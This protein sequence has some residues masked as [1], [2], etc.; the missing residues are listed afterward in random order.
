MAARPD[1]TAG[2]AAAAVRG[3]IEID[4]PPAPAGA[5]VD[6]RSGTAGD[7]AG[8]NSGRLLHEWA[9]PEVI[10]DAADGD[11]RLL[12]TVSVQF[13]VGGE[14]AGAQPHWHGPAWNWLLRGRRRWLLWPPERATYAQRHVALALDAAAR[15]GGAPPECEQRAGDVLLVPPLWGHATLNLAP[16]LGF[17]TEL[18][19]DRAFDLGAPEGR[20]AE[21]STEG[22]GT[23]TR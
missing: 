10:G 21:G 11:E 23:S 15:T 3:D 17:A 6:K 5:A 13:Y 14:G 22:E 12:R 19:F 16:S 18:Q 2:R 9:R 8:D 4:F 1:S 7:Y 20:R